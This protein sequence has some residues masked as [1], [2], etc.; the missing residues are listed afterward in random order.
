MKQNVNE[1]ESIFTKIK[2]IFFEEKDENIYKKVKK[3]FIFLVILVVIIIVNAIITKNGKVTT[4]SE[5]ALKEMFEI[6]DFSTVE[7][8]YN[9]IVTVSNDKN[10]AMYY[11]A[12]KGL[13]KIGF[14]FN[15]IK[16]TSDQKEKK[17]YINIPDIK[18]NT[19]S[20]DSSDKESLD[21]IF[22]KE[23]YNTETIFQEAYRKS[24]EDLEKKANENEQI[25][26]MANK[27]AIETIEAFIEPWKSQLPKDYKIEYK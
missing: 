9:S 11:I 25:K 23:K 4:I 8:P 21:F 1:R 20:I 18:V 15:E 16:V 14:D 13:V 2:D 7:Y 27:H 6:S 22:I 26:E 19:V 12:Y 24:I 3:I 5:S 17:I 10:E